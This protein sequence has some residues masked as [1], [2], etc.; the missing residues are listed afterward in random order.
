MFFFLWD[1]FSHQQCKGLSDQSQQ[2]LAELSGNPFNE[3][4]IL[5]SADHPLFIYDQDSEVTAENEP[6]MC[7]IRDLA[8][9]EK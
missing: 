6:L 9:Q 4:A 8:A 2:A 5:D 3:S 1:Q 7:A